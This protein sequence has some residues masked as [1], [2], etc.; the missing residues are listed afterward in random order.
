MARLSPD[1][2]REPGMLKHL[3][4]LLPLKSAGRVSMSS[5]GWTR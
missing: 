5:P 3:N 1:V 4:L 2:G